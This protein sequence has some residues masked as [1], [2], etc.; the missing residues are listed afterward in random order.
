M[1]S[2]MLIRIR[3]C[4]GSYDTIEEML[5]SVKIIEKIFFSDLRVI[6]LRVTLATTIL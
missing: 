3:A 2:V 1:L 4:H 5:L 6:R